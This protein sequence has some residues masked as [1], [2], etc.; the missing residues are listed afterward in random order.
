MNN[1][2]D[3]LEISRLKHMYCHYIDN[4]QYKKWRTLFTEGG[5]FGR[6]GADP[7]VGEEEL[8]KFNQEVFEE[9]Y[10]YSAHVLANPVIEVDNDRAEGHWYLFLLY[11]MTD[12]S[13]GWKQ[14]T[15]TDEYEKVD[16]EWLI[17]S[18]IVAFQSARE[19]GSFEVT[20]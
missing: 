14:A 16:G 3:I 5:T 17:D 1:A 9:T 7:F 4:K 10:R 15:Y 20:D 6:K 19:F 12:G 11:E 2:E 13:T 18:T 8:R